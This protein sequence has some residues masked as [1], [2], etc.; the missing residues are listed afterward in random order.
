MP[1]AHHV[2][3]GG[4]MRLPM[5]SVSRTNCI[6]PNVPKEGEMA[7]SGSMLIVIIAK[8]T[9][10]PATRSV[11]NLKHVTTT[12]Q[13]NITSTVEATAKAAV[14]VMQ[15]GQLTAAVSAIVPRTAAQLTP[16]PPR[17]RINNYDSSWIVSDAPHTHTRAPPA[18]E[19]PTVPTA[20][21]VPTAAE[22]FTHGTAH[23]HHS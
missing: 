7:P 3:V 12:T 23:V 19:A 15:I 1:P 21:T 22:R 13:N 4:S 20:H 18:L 9:P 11:Y 16:S 5:P 17:R 6:V 14:A 2:G 8:L 10:E